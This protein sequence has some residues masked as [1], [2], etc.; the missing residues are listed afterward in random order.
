MRFIALSLLVTFGLAAADKAKEEVIKEE[1]K[2][3]QG[4]WKVTKQTE[5]GKPYNTDVNKLLS[6][7][8]EGE[9]ITCFWKK[10]SEKTEG[11]VTI[12]P[13]QAPKAIDINVIRNNDKITQWGIY[14]LEGD[15]FKWGYW[16]LEATL[17]LDSDGKVK[18]PKAAR[19]PTKF[20][21]A[22]K[23]HAMVVITAER[24]KPAK[25]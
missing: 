4:T 25:R 12:D 8:I 18:L 24:D 2:K 17:E 16:H 15:T 21:D 13:T 6:F 10:P 7:I 3:L 19:R 1:L 9:K 11:Q 5:N 20:D 22:E 23:K 14:A